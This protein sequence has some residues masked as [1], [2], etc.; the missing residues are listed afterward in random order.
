M[1]KKMRIEILRR[2]FV[3]TDR[4]LR[5]KPSQAR[6]MQSLLPLCFVFIGFHVDT[7]LSWLPLVQ[8]QLIDLIWNDNIGLG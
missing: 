7:I 3:Y 6:A 1:Q 2:N 4:S 5:S 8:S